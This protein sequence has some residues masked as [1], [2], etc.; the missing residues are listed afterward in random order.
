M[1]PQTE[2]PVYRSIEAQLPR[3]WRYA[4]TLSRNNAAADDLT[5]ECVTRA[6]RK[7]EL[8]RPGTNLRAW[9]FTILHNIYVSD[10]RRQSR[11]RFAAE[12]DVARRGSSI[13]PNQEDYLALGNLGAAFERLP[14]VQ[15]RALKLV[16]IDGLSYHEAAHVLKL[17]VGTLKSKISRARARL[18]KEL[19]GKTPE[20]EHEK[21]PKKA[22]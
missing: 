22:A 18:R 8:Y 19:A 17:P 13:A 21:I 10:M 5:Q 2:N 16:S 7:C 4:L 6:L 11:F 3:L 12:A 9:L 20:A 14:P 15:R 1:T